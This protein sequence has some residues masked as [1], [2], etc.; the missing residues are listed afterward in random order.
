LLFQGSRDGFR[1]NIFHKKCDHKGKTITF[2][3]VK[4]TGR[5]FGAYTDIPWK[6]DDFGEHI[7]G[8]GNSFLFSLRDDQTI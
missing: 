8:N 3:W 4:E 6:S 5:F 2:I 7:K 1:G